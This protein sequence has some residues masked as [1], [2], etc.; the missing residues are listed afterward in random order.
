MPPKQDTIPDH[1]IE[2]T[3]LRTGEVRAVCRAGDFATVL[4]PRHSIDDY[5]R[6]Q[7]MHSIAYDGPNPT[8]T[9]AGRSVPRPRSE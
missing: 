2:L 8:E 4:M 6:L 9:I 7:Y 5:L 1:T 3:G